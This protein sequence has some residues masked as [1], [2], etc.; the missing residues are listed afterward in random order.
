MFRV[1]AIVIGL[2]LT[3]LT[4]GCEDGGRV[5]TRIDIGVQRDIGPLADMGGP[6]DMGMPDAGPL[7]TTRYMDDRTLSPV[8]PDVAAHLR[9]LAARDGS[10]DDAR[11]IKVGA[12]ATVRC[13]S[14]SPIA[15]SR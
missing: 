13:A 12:S 2:V 5:I 11:F 8:T 1:S 3:T 9:E 4:T 14:S 10:R 6:V 7:A 15:G